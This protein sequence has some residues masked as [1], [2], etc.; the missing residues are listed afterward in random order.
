MKREE[1][2]ALSRQR[3]TEAAMREFSAKGYGGASLNTVCAEHDISKG[4]IY[5]YFKDK[6]ELYLMCVEECFGTL[7]TYMQEKLSHSGSTKE[8]KLQ[9]YFDARLRFFMENPIYLGIFVDAALSPPP[10]LVD[11]IAAC[12]RDFDELNGAVLTEFL[13]RSSLREGLVVEEVVEDFRSYM[14]FFNMRFKQTFEGE[15]LSEKVIK[16]HEER[17][18]RQFDILLHGVIG[19]ENE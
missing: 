11:R 8:E 17:C 2:N 13:K 6:D 1:K 18:H 12:R 3:I 15:I 9:V 7:T 4:I 19:E 16:E 10:A 5:H 14:D